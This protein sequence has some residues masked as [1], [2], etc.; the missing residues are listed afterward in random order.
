[1]T[2]MIE[3]GRTVNVNRKKLLYIALFSSTLILFN[4]I[5][6]CGG[7]KPTRHYFNPYVAKDIK[8]PEVLHCFD[9]VGHKRG[10]FPF[11]L[12]GT[13]CCR[14]TRELLE[15]YQEDGFL[16]DYDLAGLLEEY[17]KKGIVLEHD[18]GWPCNNQCKDGPHLI[19]G[20][21]CMVPPT[22]GTQNYEN[23]ITGKKPAN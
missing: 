11:I 16:Q 14:P 19:F 13:C 22:I 8:G 15:M 6:G 21:K 7:K 20:G 1:M 3:R 23:V 18:N 12:G 10:T 17:E 9:T 5:T 2:D 4:F